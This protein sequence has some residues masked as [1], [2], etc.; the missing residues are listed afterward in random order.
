MLFLVISRVCQ[1]LFLFLFVC[2]AASCLIF[3]NFLGCYRINL[4]HLY[5]IGIRR[6]FTTKAF[7]RTS[8]TQRNTQTS[9]G[10]FQIGDGTGTSD[11]TIWAGGW[12]KS[13]VRYTVFKFADGSKNN[14]ST[15]TSLHVRARARTHI[16]MCIVTL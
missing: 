11:S 7:R 6:T 12:R 14:I 9:H 5:F 8:G 4:V 10:R 2:F 16:H 3:Y 1:C 15:H 13:Y